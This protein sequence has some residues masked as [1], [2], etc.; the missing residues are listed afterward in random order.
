MEQI[1]F[2]L[3]NMS[4]LKVTHIRFIMASSAAIKQNL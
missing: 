1:C 4:A 2:Q 3:R